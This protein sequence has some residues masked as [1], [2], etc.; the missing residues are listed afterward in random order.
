[1]DVNVPFHLGGSHIKVL[2]KSLVF[3]V[4]L[5]TLI[6]LAVA[7]PVGDWEVVSGFSSFNSIIEGK[8]I[9]TGTGLPLDKFTVSF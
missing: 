8:V 9:Y 2:R 6:T 5:A 3:I 4:L 1:M 7:S